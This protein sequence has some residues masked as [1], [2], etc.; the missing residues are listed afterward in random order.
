MSKLKFG[1]SKKKKNDHLPPLTGTSSFSTTSYGTTSFSSSDVASVVDIRPLSTFRSVASTPAL[2]DASSL[3]PSDTSTF[4]PWSDAEEPSE[5]HKRLGII[6]L[7]EHEEHDDDESIYLAYARDDNAEDDIIYEG[8]ETEESDEA[9]SDIEDGASICFEASGIRQHHERMETIVET[10]SEPSTPRASE[11][12]PLRTSFDSPFGYPSPTTPGV[13]TRSAD[14]EEDEVD[15]SLRIMRARYSMARY[16]DSSP[17]PS[18]S[19]EL[20]RDM[21]VPSPS[22]SPSPYIEGRRRPSPLATLPSHSLNAPTWSSTSPYSPSAY[23]DAS[24]RTSTSPAAMQNLLSALQLPSGISSISGLPTP[25][26]SPIFPSVPLA[27]PQSS[28]PRQSLRPSAKRPIMSRLSAT[29]L[30]MDATGEEALPPY[31][32]KATEFQSSAPPTRLRPL[33]TTPTTSHGFFM[34]SNPTISLS[35]ATSSNLSNG[36]S[37]QRL[38]D[39]PPVPQDAPR[40]PRRPARIL[41]RQSQLPPERD[42]IAETMELA[43]SVAWPSPPTSSS[44][45]MST[46]SY[47]APESHR[48][49][50]ASSFMAI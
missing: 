3:M 43:S 18:T 46:N 7:E 26:S 21:P 6:L 13:L 48:H 4:A 25:Q 8:D 49:A 32:P 36:G 45:L 15:P 23:D 38:L 17:T 50:R 31:T 37:V 27:G 19:R 24:P 2:T 28:P 11:P 5:A 35:P 39:L 16:Y 14:D 29:D 40:G 34:N 42:S 41:T 9:G 47:A 12:V 33:P 44:F 30:A 22:P 10:D 1:K 20:P